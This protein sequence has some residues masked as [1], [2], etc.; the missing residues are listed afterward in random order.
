MD[1]IELYVSVDGS[2]SGVGDSGS[3]FASMAAARDRARVCRLEHP[4]RGID[5]VLRGGV[6]RLD[7]TTDFGSA[8][9]GSDRA[10]LRIRSAPGERVVLTGTRELG[11]LER[12]DET[13]IADRLCP[14]QREHIRMV[15]LEDSGISEIDT[16]EQRGQP[17]IELYRHSR[18]LPIARF[19]AEGWLRIEDVPQAGPQRLHEGLDRERRFGDVP[20]GRHYGR[21]IYPGNGPER[22]GFHN[23]ILMHGYWTWDWNDS[24][25]MV[26]SIDTTDRAVHLAPPY[27]SYGYTTNQRFAFLNV[28]EEVD[29]PGKWCFH[30]ESGRTYLWPE[31]DDGVGYAAAVLRVPLLRFSETSQIDVTGVTCTESLGSGI[32]ISRSD[33][34]TVSGCEFSRL[35]DTAIVCS[36][37]NNLIQSCDLTDLGAG[38][39]SLDGGDRKSLTPGH[40]RVANNHIWNFSRWVRTYKHAIVVDGVSNAISHNLMHDCPQEAMYFRGNEHL[41]EY[42][43]IH[44]VTTETG[45]SGAI[46]TGRDWTWRGTVLRY[47]LI[48][49]LAGPGLHGSMGIYLDDFMSATTLYGNIFVR[50][51]RAAFIGGGRGNTVK[52][53]LFIECKASVHVDARGTSWAAYYF[54]GG[55]PVLFEAMDDMSF[56]D[57]PYSDRYP[58]LLELYGDAPAS[59]KGNEIAANVSFGGCWLELRDAVRVGDLRHVHNH[60]GD[61]VLCDQLRGEVGEDPYYLELDSTDPY[62]VIR[63]VDPEGAAKVESGGNVVAPNETPVPGWRERDFRVDESVARR[64][65]FE[66]IPHDEIGLYVDEYRTTL[67]EPK[68]LAGAI[69]PTGA[70]TK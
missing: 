18:R 30:R 64:I 20:V 25:Q 29:G 2:D 3:P 57:P 69:P 37:T 9:A 59:P 16:I 1:R 65:G 10:A 4:E 34:V 15:S 45:D 26:D 70:P 49:N 42:N 54:D 47:N 13:A 14:S 67:P 11:S 44:T 53:N 33:S 43:E 52:N 40:N 19:P 5:I 68:R 55:H 12:I 66:Q 46:H 50:A 38:G 48:H 6:Y 61:E 17:P 41:I 8:D 7:R 51:G 36:G 31:D 28:L 62:E 39:V 27:H 35:G 32:E 58:E 22:W 24:Y 56:R 63:G 21:I 60:I 23:E